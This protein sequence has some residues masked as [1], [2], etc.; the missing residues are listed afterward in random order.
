MVFLSLWLIAASLVEVRTSADGQAG[1]EEMVQIDL[2]TKRYREYELVTPV[3]TNLKGH[4]LSHILS[5]NHKKRSPRDVSSNSEQLFFNVT[6]FGRDFHLR[7]RPNTHFIAP[8]A[9]VEW[10]ETAP[11]P[12]NTTD[13][14]NSRPHRSSSEGGWRSEPLQTSCAYVGDIMDVPGTSVAISN[15]DGLAFVVGAST[16]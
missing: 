15:C 14:R 1:A 13:P 12:G 3:S 11:R 4:Y 7:L 2:P 6:A 5:A 10:H 8:G 16:P 9:V